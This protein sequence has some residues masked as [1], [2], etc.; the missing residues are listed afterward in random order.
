[1]KTIMLR[2]AQGCKGT[3]AAI[4]AKTESEKD[5]PVGDRRGCTL[6][7]VTDYGQEL[8]TCL[9]VAF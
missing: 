6:S 4:E 9:K 3:G 7:G 1:L 2:A 8:P 5:H